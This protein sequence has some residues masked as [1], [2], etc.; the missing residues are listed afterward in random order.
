M[1]EFVIMP[2]HIRGIMTICDLISKVWAGS[3]PAPTMGGNQ[4]LPEIV[5]QLKTFS[6]KCTNI[7]SGTPKT[8]VWLRNYYEHIIRNSDE[9]EQIKWYIQN[10]P[11]QWIPEDD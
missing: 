5:R 8:P 9:F 1:G 2:D 7:I 4:G 10:N 11:S 3:E 6:S